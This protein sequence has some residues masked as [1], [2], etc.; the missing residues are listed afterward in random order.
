MPAPPAQADAGRTWSGGQ[1]ASRQPEGLS[2]AQPSGCA[3]TGGWQPPAPGSTSRSTRLLAAG[4]VLLAAALGLATAPA[5]APLDAVPV[6]AVHTPLI[7]LNAATAAELELLP[8]IGPKL[9]ARIVEDRATNGPFES[10]EALDRVKGIGP[11]TVARV[12]PHVRVDQ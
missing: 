11:R 3:R 1:P 4:A 6:A 9:A 12:R 2:D 10:V 8:R 5:R 7:D